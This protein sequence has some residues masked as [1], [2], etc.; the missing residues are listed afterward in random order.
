MTSI[1]PVIGIDGSRL[2]CQQS[3]GTEN[4]SR[5]IVKQLLQL[6]VPLRWRLYL[7][8]TT[9]SRTTL[10]WST[11]V[12]TRPIPAPR[13][14]T[15][16]RLSLETVRRR[17]DL[18]FVPSHVVPIIHPRSVVTIHD[19]GY[20]RYPE[21]HPNGQRRM[22]D[23]ST[24]WSAH[25]A[26]HIIVP[27]GTTKSDLV[28]AYG[29][30]DQKISVIH[31]GVSER[32]GAIIPSRTRDLRT[33]LQL[34]APYILSVGTIQPRK[35]FEFLGEA[36]M[37]LRDRGTECTLVIAGKRGWLA[38]QVLD[39]LGALD[40][41]N[42]LRILDYVSDDDLPALYAGAAAYVQ[43]SLYEGF[44]LPVVEAMSSGV[45]VL[46]STASCLPEIAADG[47]EV[48][49]PTDA[50]HLG[51][52]LHDILA[53]RELSRAMAARALTRSKHFSWRRAAE[54]TASVLLGQLR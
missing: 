15:H 18:L 12:E 22:L 32:F 50:D 24:R 13:L 14:W 51:S 49:D 25:A 35:N 39:R 10:D 53:S 7:N 37:A 45:P 30:D 1:L 38:D 26:R 40:L 48:F 23:L 36:M 28:E 41:G 29:I 27:S 21:M 5:E 17:P 34:S 6:D 20:L 8:E 44:G 54:Q 3:T 16:G 52:A 9:S 47:A 46:V 31:H 33:R 2:S 19:L 43:P 42:R 11:R 4:Y